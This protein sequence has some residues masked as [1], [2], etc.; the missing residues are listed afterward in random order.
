MKVTEKSTFTGEMHLSGYF[1]RFCNRSVIANGL[2]NM[3]KG[4]HFQILS[5]RV[6]WG[7]MCQWVNSVTVKASRNLSSF[8]QL[9]P[10]QTSMTSHFPSGKLKEK[11]AHLT[12]PP[13]HKHVV[14]CVV[15]V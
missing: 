2:L 10:L 4:I 5:N 8:T 12:K 7:K 11:V 3:T 1:L 6:E 13:I 14:E 15:C 9:M